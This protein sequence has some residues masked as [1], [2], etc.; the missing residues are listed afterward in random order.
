MNGATLTGVANFGAPPG[1]EV[2]T[3]ADYNG[4]GK[5]DLLWT[6]NDANDRR[7]LSWVSRTGSGYDAKF[8]GSRGS[9]WMIPEADR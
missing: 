6:S 4:D 3:T 2:A 1:F 8:I 5:S 7:L 9:G